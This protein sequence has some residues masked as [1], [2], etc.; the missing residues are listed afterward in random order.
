MQFFNNDTLIPAR[1]KRREALILL[2]T[3]TNY[4]LKL[5][6][7]YRLYEKAFNVMGW[8]SYRMLDLQFENQIVAV[9]N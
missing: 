9:R 4:Q 6:R 2:G 7:L 1:V 3:T 8:N 5:N